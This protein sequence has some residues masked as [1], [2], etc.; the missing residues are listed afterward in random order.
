MTEKKEL[1]DYFGK[2]P[3]DTG[4]R[5]GGLRNDL[6]VDRHGR[7]TEMSLQLPSGLTEPKRLL[8]QGADTG[9][10]LSGSWGDEFL[11]SQGQKTRFR[12]SAKARNEIRYGT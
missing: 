9:Y 2:T 6:I 5:L 11:D 7:E 12:V 4:F 3:G 1:T 8:Y 10:R